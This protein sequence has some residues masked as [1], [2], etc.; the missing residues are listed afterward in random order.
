MSRTLD[1]IF[2]AK[3]AIRG[4]LVRRSIK[5]LKE[6]DCYEELITMARN[7]CFQVYEIG[8][9]VVVFC[10]SVPHIRRLA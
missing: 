2:D 7:R 6:N 8:D 10:S 4:G 9:Q 1:G 3:I 5:S